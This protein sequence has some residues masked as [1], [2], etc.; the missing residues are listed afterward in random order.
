MVLPLLGASIFAQP[1]RGDYTPPTPYVLRSANVQVTINLLTGSIIDMQDL[2]RPRSPEVFGTGEEALKVTAGSFSPLPFV[3]T[4][5]DPTSLTIASSGFGSGASRLPLATTIMYRLIGDR[6]SVEYRFEAVGRADM[7]DGLDL[8]IASSS[9]DSISVRNQYSGEERMVAGQGWGTRNCA[10]NQKYVFHNSLRSLTLVFPNPYNSLV[11]VTMPAPHGLDFR[12]RALVSVPA[13]QARDPKGPRLASVLPRGT[14]I[15]RQIEMIVGHSSGEAPHPVSP[16]AYFSPFPNGYDQAIAMTFDDIP[17]GRWV[18]PTSGYDTNTTSEKYLIRLL[19]DHPKMKMGW[20]VLL[21]EILDATQLVTPGYPPGMWW[22][23]HGRHRILTVAPPAFVQEMRNI[24]GDSIVLGYEKRVHLGSHGYHHTPE[25]LFGANYEFQSYDT[26]GN[27]STFATIE[28]EFALLGLHARSLKWIRFPGYYFTRSAIESLIKF[29]FSLFDYWGIYDKLPWMQ[30]YSEHGRIWGVGTY[31]EGDTPSP[32]AEMDKI[33]RAGH[34]CHTGGHPPQWFDG[35]SEAS[36]RLISQMFQQ[37]EMTYR[38]L[39][40]M[41]PDEVGQFADETSQIHD[42]TTDVTCDSYVLAFAGAATMGQTIV[43]EWPDGVPA[44]TDVTVDGLPAS[45]QV[46]GSRVVIVLPALADRTHF[47]QI[48]ADLCS[49]YDV[50]SLDL[51]EPATALVL[52]QNYPNPFNPQTYVSYDLPRAAHVRMA[53]YNSAGEQVAVLVDSDQSPGRHAVRWNGR[54]GFGRQAA[55]GI[56]FC[57]LEAGAESRVR[58]LV[59][60]R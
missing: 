60:V 39:G 27:D 25:M 9:W 43:V 54:D 30:F 46:R 22:M 24:D 57:R 6:L 10:L 20:I 35:D 14:K 50:N 44:P 19:D 45:A 47:V 3:V 12:W 32:Y 21:D 4:G 7:I 48:T 51:G 11:T 38:N 18:F 15:Y 56:Y 59:L 33:L 1:A 26:L 49:W 31:W 36:Y 58:K 52:D 13:F 17:F 16:I 53:I 8:E 28:R 23:A 29:K 41:F 5:G 34:L 37:A 42:I 2:A 55:S 40:Y